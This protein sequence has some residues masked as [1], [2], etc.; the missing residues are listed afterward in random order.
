MEFYCFVLYIFVLFIL[1][2]FIPSFLSLYFIYSPNLFSCVLIL[3]YFLCTLYICL[4]YF[5]MFYPFIS[6]LCTLYICLVDF[7]RPIP[8]FF[9]QDF[10]YLPKMI[11]VWL[12][13]H[14]F[15]LYLIYSLNSFLYAL[16]LDSFHWTPC[17]C[18]LA[19]SI[20][21]VLVLQ[22]FLC[23]RHS[24]AIVSFIIVC[25]SPLFLVL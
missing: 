1:M 11:L 9:A 7:P 21:F 10:K 14:F 5:R 3:H 20:F 12:F 16:F 13:L 8:P 2:C 4:V 15:S 19:Y 22:V 6:F 17:I 24:F 25:F 23:T 18:P